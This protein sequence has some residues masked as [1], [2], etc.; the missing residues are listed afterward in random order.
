[1]KSP[2]SE[3]EKRLLHMISQEFDLQ[4][5]VIVGHKRRV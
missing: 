3:P 1:V 5:D 4:H 2:E